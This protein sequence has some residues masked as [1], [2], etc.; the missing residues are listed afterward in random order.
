MDPAAIPAEPTATALL[1]LAF[2]LMLGVSVIFS[3]ASEAFTVPV[4]LIF[5]VIGI[6]AG[7][8]GIGRIPFE[9]Y[10][11]AFRLG[12]VALV[13]ILFDGGLNTPLSAVRL[14]YRPAGVLATIG[15]IATAGLLAVVAVLLGIDWPSALV[16]GAIVSSTDAAAVF[17][18]LRG[19]GVHLKRRVGATV[20]GESGANDPMAVI[21]T[22]VLAGNMLRP[23]AVE[24]WRIPIDVV[25]QLAVGGAAGLAIGYGGR[26]LFGRLRLPAGGLYPALS[27]ALACLAFGIPTLL[28]G[29][30]FLAVYVAGIVLGNG[31]LPYRAGLFRVHDALAW[32]SQITMFLVLGLLAFPSRLP[33]VALVGLTLALALAFLVRP[34][35]VWLC[36]LPFRY[37]RREVVYIGWVGLRGAVPI[38]LSIFPVLVGVPGAE[39]IFDVVF[40]IVVVNAFLPGATVA[41]AAR[42]LGIQSSAPREPSTTIAIE[43]VEPL[44]TNV[45]SFLVSPELA[46]AGAAVADV[47]LPEG[48][49]ITMVARG[50]RLLPAAPDLVL[51]PGDQ[52]YL[53]VRD[54][55][56]AMAR[57]LFGRPEEE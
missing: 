38:I 46:V 30:G 48:M 24:L 41:W 44:A 14:T 18:V 51:Q 39:R 53:L 5:L 4:A 36:L 22:T 20:E 57:L 31:T 28:S 42:R 3:R 17:A 7:S 21:L 19:S 9:D 26:A 47:P 54:E 32:L 45:E 11:F 2:G 15:V 52:V 8:E 37:G 29:S 40:F 10:G 35:V 13:L 55:D 6:L 43:S 33:D 12:T 34:L 1:L 49:A 23:G 50:S 27:L 56:R 16:L 25:V